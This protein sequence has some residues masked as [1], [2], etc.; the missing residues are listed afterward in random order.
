[1]TGTITVERVRDWLTPYRV[2]V[3]PDGPGNGSTA[4][5]MAGAKAQTYALHKA[6]ETGFTLVYKV[7][8]PANSLAGSTN[9][10][11]CKPLAVTVEEFCARIT[12]ICAKCRQAKPLNTF[13]REFHKNRTTGR[14]V[15]HGY[16]KRCVECEPVED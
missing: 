12:R 3:E 5:F 6:E 1:M 13:G 4:Q 2:T 9:G 10:D 15:F 7:D 14:V 16:T 8:G 11:S